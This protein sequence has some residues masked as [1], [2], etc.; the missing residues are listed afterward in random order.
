[1]QSRKVMERLSGAL[2]SWPCGTA[3][4]QGATVPPYSAQ[5]VLEG[6]G[7]CEKAFKPERRPAVSGGCRTHTGKGSAGG[8]ITAGAV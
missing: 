6:D 8:R 2:L 3:T 4:I 7:L 1:M 5:R